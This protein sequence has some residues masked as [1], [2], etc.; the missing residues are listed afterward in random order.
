MNTPEKITVIHFVHTLYG[1][2]ANV[3]AN[4]MNYQHSNGYKTVLAYC[5]YDSAIE[6]QLNHSCE[7]I[8]IHIPSFPGATMMFGMNIANIYK[9]YT[10]A[11]PDEFVIVHAHNVQTLGALANWKKIPVICTLHGFN[12][13]EKSARKIFSDFLYKTALKNLSK[14]KKKITA[15]SKAIT[16]A[17]ECDIIKNKDEI[18]VIRNFADV[19]LQDKKPHET[20][21]VGHVGDLSYDKGFDTFWKSCCILPEEY[22]KS[23]SFCAAGNEADYTAES[24]QAELNE[25]NISV[26]FQY[27]GY[28]K[29]AKID[30]IS[31]LDVLVLASR[32]E[33]LGLVQIEAMGYGIPV[34]G[35]YT[36]GICEVLKDQYNGFVINDEHQLCEKILLLHNDKDLYDKLSRNALET[37]NNNFT[38]CIIMEKYAQVYN[39]LINGCVK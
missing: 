13:P 4:L 11:H 25:K 6:T 26:P 38:S 39:E 8:H 28:V 36:G 34:L 30:F 27:D 15:V 12:C 16:E 33:G 32:N 1:G 20:F 9:K 10:K 2:V 29:N 5:C 35:R 37:Y 18:S 7:K 14:H 19:L 24:L 31:K 22:K 3:A 23:V 21:T 17:P